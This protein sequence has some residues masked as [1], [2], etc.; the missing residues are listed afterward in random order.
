MLTYHRLRELLREISDE[1]AKVVGPLL[2]LAAEVEALLKSGGKILFPPV[3]ES[4]RP[5]HYPQFRIQLGYMT[6]VLEPE[7]AVE[8]ERAKLGITRIGYRKLRK[9]DRIA[10]GQRIPIPKWTAE[11]FQRWSPGD[12]IEKIGR[13]HY[14]AAGRQLT[15]KVS[16]LLPH[17]KLSGFDLDRIQAE[18]TLLLIKLNFHTDEKSF[19][20]LSRFIRRIVKAAGIPSALLDETTMDVLGSLTEHYTS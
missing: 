20:H 8:F 5:V 17:K 1:Y 12:N 16:V 14:L 10:F 18:A 11:G 6:L 3:E 15:G 9:L 19:A 7:I 13:L 2:D 4:V